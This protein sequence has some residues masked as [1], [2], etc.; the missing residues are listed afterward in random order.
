[1]SEKNGVSQERD[2]EAQTQQ[3]GAK[4]AKHALDQQ[5]PTTPAAVTSF[6][7][8]PGLACLLGICRG[9][10]RPKELHFQLYSIL[11]HLNSHLNRCVWPVDTVL[12]SQF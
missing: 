7:G 9:P 2:D 8:C 12:V 4:M 5:R 10:T 6:C 3:N 11:V 1:M